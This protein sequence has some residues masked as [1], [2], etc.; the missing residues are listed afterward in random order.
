MTLYHLAQINVATMKAPL[1]SP[2]M[3]DF[4]NNLDRINTL[5]ESSDGFVWRLQ[6]DGGDA[7]ELR[8]LGDDVL[9]NVSVWR[10][11]ESLRQF[12]Y[13]S[14]HVQIMGR[15][16]EWFDKMSDASTALWWIPVGHT[17][18]VIEA[19]EKLTQLQLD[20]STEQAFSLHH[21]FPSPTV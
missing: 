9:V 16:G 11:F 6:T 8:P 12:V 3:A 10:D 21:V 19:C 14:A 1:D 18:T 20:G 4:V 15:R 2:I 7:T 13:L 5:A 17:P